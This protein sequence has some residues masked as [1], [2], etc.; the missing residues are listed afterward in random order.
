MTKEQLISTMPGEFIDWHIERAVW[1]IL[2]P[3]LKILNE[4]LSK[5]NI[6]YDWE[7]MDISYCI[8]QNIG[9]GI[10]E[11]LIER[12]GESSPYVHIKSLLDYLK[13]IKECGYK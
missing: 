12:Q 3:H 8:K 7:A 5:K 1:G 10:N 11:F 6:E 4:I 2:G 9:C 13:S